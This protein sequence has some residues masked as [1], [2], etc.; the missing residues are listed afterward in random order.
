MIVI[1]LELIDR[2][3]AGSF[4]FCCGGQRWVG[5]YKAHRSILESEI[6]HVR[7]ADGPDIDAILHV[8]QSVSH[9]SRSRN[10]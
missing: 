8:N 10:R 4:F 2:Y 6:N 1:G 5:S 7:R 9:R 3:F